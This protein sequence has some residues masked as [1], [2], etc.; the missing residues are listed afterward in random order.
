MSTFM[1]L[2]TQNWHCTR[3]PPLPRQTPRIYRPDSRCRKSPLPRSQ[4][5]ERHT[6]VR[7][8]LSRLPPRSNHPQKQGKNRTSSRC[9]SRSGS[10]LRRLKWRWHWQLCWTR[11]Q[12]QGREPYQS[13]GR[14]EFKIWMDVFGGKM[15]VV[16]CT[17]VQGQR[18]W[19][20]PV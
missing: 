10:A 15:T 16:R 7:Y 13:S 18:F 20:S 4:V 17:I 2:S 12:R 9:Q 3:F 6:K 11:G 1:I 19:K 8:H 14:W 5:K